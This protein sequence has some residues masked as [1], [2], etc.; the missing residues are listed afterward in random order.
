MTETL[1]LVVFQSENMLPY[2]QH[3]LHA[4]GAPAQGWSRRV[5]PSRWRKPRSKAANPKPEGGRLVGTGRTPAATSYD[6]SPRRQ[7]LQFPLHLLNLGL[8][9]GFDRFAERFNFRVA[10]GRLLAH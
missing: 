9:D 6:R 2:S 3:C 4:R 1:H 8:L 5:L 7:V 10:D